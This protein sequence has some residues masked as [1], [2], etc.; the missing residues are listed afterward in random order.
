MLQFF[1]MDDSELI[2]QLQQKVKEAEELLN[3]RREALKALK[4][5][6]GA[7]N[8]KRARGF[9]ENSIPALIHAALKANKQPLSLDELVAHFKRTHPTLELDARKISLA[10]SKYVRKGQHFVSMDGK[11]GIK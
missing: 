10:L 5:Q 2:E 6:R 11:Y 4:G 3:R 8:G 9:R 7:K 1:P